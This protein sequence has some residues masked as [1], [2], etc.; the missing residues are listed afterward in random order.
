[1][2][3]CRCQKWECIHEQCL[4]YTRARAQKNLKILKKKKKKKIFSFRITRR[5]DSFLPYIHVHERDAAAPYLENWRKC[6]RAIRP[7]P[8][9]DWPRCSRFPGC[10]SHSTRCSRLSSFRRPADCPADAANGI[11]DRCTYGICDDKQFIRYIS[12]Y[13]W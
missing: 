1:M 6:R 9:M 2:K 7:R 13:K 10:C 12:I 8:N 11:F 3:H 5:D 4:H